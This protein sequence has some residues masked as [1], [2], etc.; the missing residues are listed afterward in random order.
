MDL[1]SE[2]ELAALEARIRGINAAAS[3]VR[4]QRSRVDL[5]RVL[6]CGA[7]S[8]A[9]AAE[10]AAAAAGADEHGHGQA[11]PAACSTSHTG[12]HGAGKA[13]GEGEHSRVAEAAASSGHSYAA[14]APSVAGGAGWDGR[15]AAPAGNDA[16]SHRRAAPAANG[17]HLA[18]AAAQ[19]HAAG[20]RDCHMGASSSS[21]WQAQR[22]DRGG[23]AGAAG[24]AGS[25]QQ[26]LDG[27]RFSSSGA[28]DSGIA[29]A[30]GAARH[31]HDSGL[32]TVSVRLSKDLCLTRFGLE[33][34]LQCNR[35]PPV[36]AKQPLQEPAGPCP[37][38]QQSGGSRRTHGGTAWVI[39]LLLQ[40]CVAA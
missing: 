24:P 33:A 2:Q 4:T 39:A 36:A 34:V 20:V 37:A 1:A 14:A 21:D 23:F 18:E 15:H 17:I 38:A 6:H 32:A 5:A 12:V 30:H 3:L 19:Q 11:A 7:F 9:R 13:A 27:R 35:C 29:E 25:G 22:D 8:S 10:A 16:S 40:A 28:A 31:V 26:H